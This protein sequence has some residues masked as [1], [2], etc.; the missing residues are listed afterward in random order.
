M[1]LNYFRLA[2]RWHRVAI[3]NRTL[4]ELEDRTNKLCPDG[5]SHVFCKIPSLV[6]QL[7]MVGFLQARA[8]DPLS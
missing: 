2:L 4:S 3:P 7:Y 6:R 1:R 8:L 5:V